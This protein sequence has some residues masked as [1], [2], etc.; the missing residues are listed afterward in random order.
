M[1]TSA[2]DP[3]RKLTASRAPFPSVGFWISFAEKVA[4]PF[5]FDEGKPFHLDRAFSIPA[6]EPSCIQLEYDRCDQS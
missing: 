4:N 1:H 2:F 5:I 3:K 6:K